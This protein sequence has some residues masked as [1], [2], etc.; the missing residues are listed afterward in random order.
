MINSW[1]DWKEVLIAWNQ[2]DD[3]FEAEQG[4]VIIMVRAV[5]GSKSTNVG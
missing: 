5:Y 2:Q 3:E 1:I 4:K